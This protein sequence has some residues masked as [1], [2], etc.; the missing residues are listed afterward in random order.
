MIICNLFHDILYLNI[1]HLL[2]NALFH[3]RAECP[4]FWPPFPSTRRPHPS[5]IGANGR[6]GKE[7]EIEIDFCLE[8]GEIENDRQNKRRRRT[9]AQNDLAGLGCHWDAFRNVIITFA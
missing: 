4:S 6:G 1:R 5:A 3:V 8:S 2:Y 7:G 9:G